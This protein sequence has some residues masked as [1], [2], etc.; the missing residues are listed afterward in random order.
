MTYSLMGEGNASEIPKGLIT[1]L[2]Q[3]IEKI[4]N[5][6][7]IFSLS[8]IL[9]IAVV[10]GVNKNINPVL[11][12]SILTI[13]F[14]AV[15]V[16]SYY[17]KEKKED[18]SQPF[19]YGCQYP[20]F[21]PPFDKDTGKPYVGTVAFP[22]TFTINNDSEFQ[23]ETSIYIQ[24]KTQAVGFV[25]DEETTKWKRKF[26]LIPYRETAELSLN[27]TITQGVG[28]FAETKFIF[29]GIYRPM[30]AWDDYRL[31]KQITLHYRIIMKSDKHQYDS[32]MK[33]LDIPFEEYYEEDQREK[34]V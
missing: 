19:S 10:I 25:L 9:I 13:Y 14:I 34:V 5:E 3:T 20:I 30:S 28:P 11:I 21:T 7:L 32:L 31:R 16:Y 27:Q 29:R 22:I 33:R 18:V 23:Y 8:I 17:Y 12:L 15:F 6:F 24:S 26:V 1:L 4:T 2:L